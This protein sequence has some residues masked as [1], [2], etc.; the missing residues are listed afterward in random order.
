MALFLG[1]KFGFEL[2]QLKSLKLYPS[3]ALISLVINSCVSSELNWV[4]LLF[5]KIF[6]ALNNLGS[7]LNQILEGDGEFCGPWSLSL[8][9]PLS[10]VNWRE[11]MTDPI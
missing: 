6:N 5:L 3:I 11:I 2:I 9:F 10:F 8:S 7:F 4:A 1:W